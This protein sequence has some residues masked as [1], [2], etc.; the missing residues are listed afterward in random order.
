[1]LI[2]FL[3]RLGDP[4]QAPPPAGHYA[5]TTQLCLGVGPACIHQLNGE[6]QGLNKRMEEKFANIAMWQMHMERRVNGI[7]ESL[8]NFEVWQQDMERRVDK[9]EERLVKVEERLV[10]VE[11]R[12][13]KVDQRLDAIENSIKDMNDKLQ[14]IL[15]KLE[16][17]EKMHERGDHK[18][19]EGGKDSVELK[20]KELGVTVSGFPVVGLVIGFWFTIVIYVLYNQEWLAR[21]D[22]RWRI[23]DELRH[24]S[25]KKKVDKGEEE[26]KGDKEEGE[27]GKIGCVLI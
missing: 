13:D 3:G 26:V 1:M 2:G 20:A 17:M 27:D 15:Q 6:I 4:A 10:K 18:K 21:R 12:L 8:A 19:E 9:I 5:E 24:E 22:R 14:T 11:E 23:R 25:R 7:E 16:K